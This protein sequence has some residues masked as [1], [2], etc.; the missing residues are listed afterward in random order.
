MPLRAAVLFLAAAALSACASTNPSGTSRSR[1]P[2][3]TVTVRDLERR[4]ARLELRLLEKEAQVDELETRL[5]DAREEVVRTMAKLET[6]AS[7]AEAASAMA[8]AEVALQSLRN[9][10]GA[11][12]LP[13]LARTQR[14]VQH[15]TAEFN[16]QNYGGAL[17][18][19]AEAKSAATAG[20]A[21]LSS[22]QRGAARPGETPFALPIRLKVANRGNV[23][24]GPGTN[25]DVAFAVEGGNALTG[26]AY[27]DEW[28]RVIDDGGRS[29]WIYRTLITRP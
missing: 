12:Q 18:L 2:R 8:E 24:E 28:V 5:S 6:L 14:L 17:Y 29:G 9:S 15:S 10:D 26:F 4:A 1:G 11:R 27:T 16:K 19:A 13:E 22:G 20:R 23:R 3:E 21:R 7:R 25:F